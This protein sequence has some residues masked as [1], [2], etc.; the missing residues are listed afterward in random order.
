MKRGVFFKKSSWTELDR[1]DI[2]VAVGS[3]WL[4]VAVAQTE[5]NVLLRANYDAWRMNDARPTMKRQLR[6][7][8]SSKAN[9]KEQ[10]LRSGPSQAKPADRKKECK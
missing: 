1:Y 9:H 6:P 7:K 2:A 4:V 10:P 5:S 8:A 3:R